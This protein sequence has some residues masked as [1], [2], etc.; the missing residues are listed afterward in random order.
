[1]SK[2][3]RRIGRASSSTVITIQ[4]ALVTFATLIVIYNTMEDIPNSENKTDIKQFSLKDPKN[5]E[6]ADNRG[7]TRHLDMFR[8]KFSMTQRDQPYSEN[9]RTGDNSIQMGDLL[10]MAKSTAMDQILQPSFAIP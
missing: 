4:G 2:T 7:E 8:T 6:Q 9:S 3:R 1:V 5:R 10:R